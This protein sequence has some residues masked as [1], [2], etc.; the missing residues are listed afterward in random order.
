[1]GMEEGRPV[2]LVVDDE[3]NI[4]KTVARALGKEQYDV[5]TAVNGE[6]ALTM[7]EEFAGGGRQGRP[8]GGRLP[9]CGGVVEAGQGRG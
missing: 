9:A 5:K 7:I 2:I 1:L 4:R 8:A 6:E 3:I